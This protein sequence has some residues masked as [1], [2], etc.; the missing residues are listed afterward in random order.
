MRSM[1]RLAQNLHVKNLIFLALHLVFLAKLIT[2]SNRYLRASTISQD[3]TQASNGRSFNVQNYGAV[4]NGVHD[5]TEAF[6]SAWNDACK[7]SSAILHVAGGKTYLVNNLNFLGPCQ[8]GFKFQVD[9][10]IVAPDNPGSWKSTHVW[11]S[12]QHLQQFTLTGK[13]TI[14]GRGNNWWGK[15][16]SRP[17]AIQFNDV[18]GSAL[19]GLKVTNSPEFHVTLTNCDSVQIV[20]ITIQAPESSPNTDGIDTFQS[21][22]IVIK[23]STIGTGDDCIG[24]GDGSSNIRISDITCGPGHGIS[25][26]SLGKGNTKADVHSIHVNGAKLKSTTNGLRIKT[27]QGGSGMASDITYEN[28]QMEDVSNP[29]IINQ[30]YCDTGDTGSVCKAQGSAVKISNVQYSNIRGTSATK[31]GITLSCSQSGSCTGITME[32]IDLVTN[33]GAHA[34]C[35]AQH[36]K[37]RTLGVVIPSAC[38]GKNAK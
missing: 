33:S 27:W 37:A 4:G 31:D 30:F 18:K 6:T 21:T 16:K 2:A 28:V 34:A 22:N 10:T 25:I 29:I 38:L 13:G 23:D 32:N 36:V 3:A 8:P 35:N 20:G 11:L 7:A 5:D 9:G 12:F 24:I 17:T 26:G 15:Q 1:A 14:D 19:S